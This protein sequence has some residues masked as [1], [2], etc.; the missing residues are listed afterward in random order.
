MNLSKITTAFAATVL[1][2]GFSLAS[3]AQQLNNP[4]QDGIEVITIIGKRPTPVLDGIEVITITGKRPSP[5]H[6]GIEVITIVGVRPASTV[7]STCVDTGTSQPGQAI[8][9]S[10]KTV[11]SGD[12]SLARRAN[13]D[14][15]H[16]AR[17][18]G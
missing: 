15:R 8:E 17:Q 16:C 18:A 5:A 11:T 1:V 2:A 9:G 3:S 10:E 6:E 7:A 14:A 4:S 12:F 13:H